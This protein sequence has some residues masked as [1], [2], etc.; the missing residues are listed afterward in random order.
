M[1]SLVAVSVDRFWAV[2]EP[3]TYH[4][5][6]KMITKISIVCCWTGGFFI[7]FLPTFGWNSGQTQ[8]RCDLRVVA[9][10]SYMLFLCAIGI[11]TTVLIITLYV[12]IYLAILKQARLALGYKDRKCFFNFWAN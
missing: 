6:S 3:V 11:I 12:L 8:Y 4:V 7:G 1:F 5:A 2:Y 9:D 10:F